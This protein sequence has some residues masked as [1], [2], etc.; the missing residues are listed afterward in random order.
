MAI[1]GCADRKTERFLAGE[2]VREFEAFS[3]KAVM[4]LTRLQ[5]AVVLA[6]LWKPPSNHFEALGGN[7]KGQYSIRINKKNR[8]C[9]RWVRH[10]SVPADADAIQAAGD[11]DYVEIEIDYH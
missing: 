10:P 11:A 3:E 4:A 5:A 8:V 2:Q 6:D 7:R 9:F 1:I